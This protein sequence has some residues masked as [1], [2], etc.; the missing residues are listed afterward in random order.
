MVVQFLYEPVIIGGPVVV[1]VIQRLQPVRKPV[2]EIAGFIRGNENIEFFVMRGQKGIQLFKV[3]P[4]GVK[5]GLI[6]GRVVGLVKQNVRGLEK[7][8]AAPDNDVGIRGLY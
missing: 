3:L 2:A 1:P 7:A 4:Q 6:A 8:A 5:V